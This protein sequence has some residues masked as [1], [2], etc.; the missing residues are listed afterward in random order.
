M[1][2]SALGPTGSFSE[3]A[4]IRYAESVSEKTEIRLYATILAAF[5]AIGNECDEGIVPIENMLEGHVSLSLDLLAG[6]DIRIVKELL[7]PIHFSFVGNSPSLDAISKVHIQS[8]TQGQCRKF[9]KTLPRT[10]VIE[11]SQSNSASFE[12][13]L[14]HIPGEGAIVPL[15]MAHTSEHFPIIINNVHDHPNNMTRFAVLSKK[16][17]P[18]DSSQKYR[19]SIVILD[20][21]DE[22]G[23]LYRILGELEDK[24]LNL[25]SIISR[26]NKEQFGKYHFFMDIEA[27]YPE[28]SNLKTA[29]DN[30]SIKNRIKVLGSY[31]IAKIAD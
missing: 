20:V 5:E 31:P 10:A 9:L 19:T 6:A 17:Y 26:P 22:P 25:S 2:I 4:A 16:D 8:V 15:H 29:L 18:H 21:A 3:L 1:R 13:A 7:L 27:E 28:S 24:N 12:E 14:K 11:T 30:I 23:A